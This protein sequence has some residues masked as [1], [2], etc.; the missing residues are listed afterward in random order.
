LTAKK[1]TAGGAVHGGAAAVFCCA[2]S[3]PQAP[4][5]LPGLA[6]AARAGGW[7]VVPVALSNGLP[8][9]GYFAMPPGDRRQWEDVA[10]LRV[11]G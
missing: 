1:L 8:E 7:R 4:A 11:G 5:D 9:S 3:G 6:E 10:G 2:R